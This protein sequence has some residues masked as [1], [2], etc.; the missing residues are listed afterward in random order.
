MKKKGECERAIRSLCHEWAGGLSEAERDHPNFLAFKA[1]LGQ[2][3]YSH[4]LDF[5]SAMGSNYDAEM[6]F[7][8]EL[9]QTWRR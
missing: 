7:D 6:W 2:K 1:W 8:Q 4:Y 5:R 3:G 9:K